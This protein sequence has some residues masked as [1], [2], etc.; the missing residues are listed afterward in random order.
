MFELRLGYGTLALPIATCS[1]TAW[2]NRDVL[3][4]SLCYP[5]LSQDTLT[6]RQVTS[7]LLGILTQR[8]SRCH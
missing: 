6:D 8:H 4:T 5:V 3:V 2:V 7:G 1:I